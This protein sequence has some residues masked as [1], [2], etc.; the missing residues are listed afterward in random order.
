LLFLLNADVIDSERPELKMSSMKK[1]FMTGVIAAAGK[2]TRAYP[3]TTFI[4]KPLFAFENKS[5][6]ERNIEIQIKIFKVKKLYILVGHLKDIVEGEVDRLRKKFPGVKI[7]TALWTKKGL[8]SDV[9]SLRDRIDG[10][11]SLILGD[12]FYLNTDHDYMLKSWNSKKNPA[13]MIATL[14]TNFISDIRK[15]YSVELEKDRVV[16]LYEKPQTPQNTLLGLGSY[17][18][19]REYF[20]YFD[21]TKPSSRSGVVE[22]TDVI[23][24]MASDSKR[25]YSS[26]LKGRYYNINSLADY[27]TVNY[28]LRSEKFAKYKT[29]L[30]IPVL[31]NEFTISD[32]I[33]DF[34]K[35]V[36]EIIVVDMGSKDQT[37][38]IVKSLPVK[39]LD[40]SS[41]KNKVGIHYAPSIYNA[42]HQAKGDIIVLAAGDGSFRARDLPKLLEYLKDCDMVVGTRTTRQMMEQGANLNS[43]Y[44][45]LNVA[46]GKLVEIFWWDQEPR[47][48][49]IGCIYRAIWKDSFEKISP[50]LIVKDKTFSVEMM[51]EIVRYHMRCIEIPISFYRSYGII[52]EEK[53]KA[54][55]FYLISVLLLVFSKK[56]RIFSFLIKNNSNKSRTT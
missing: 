9:A 25:V 48:T 12:E 52:A 55:F 39:L 23:D 31:N 7:E 17:M 37:K 18:F 54:Q 44:R 32:V 1:T 8:A 28:L 24:L 42:M 30:V 34:K 43:L 22:L 19:S 51:I 46:L 56:F 35:D 16:Q 49:D 10:D 36:N 40:G 38:K 21:K 4:P 33:S 15:N 27:Y 47:F 26:L 3:R 2:G 20:D 41:K 5:L 6:L 14:N 53:I 45:W 50:D 11:F 29:S 13:A